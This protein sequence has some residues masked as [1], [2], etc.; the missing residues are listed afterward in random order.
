MLKMLKVLAI[1]LVFSIPLSAQ[2]NFSFHSGLNE[3]SLITRSA[4]QS[5]YMEYLTREGFRPEID[6]DGDIQFRILG[7][8]YFIIIDE[9]D[10]QFF[11]IYTGF[12]LDSMMSIDI[13]EALELVNITN[14]RSK[15][16]K[17]SISNPENSDSLSDRLVVSI[18]AELLLNEPQDFRL[19]F[20]RA[21]SLLTN[22]KNLFQ[23]QLASR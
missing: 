7:N 9:N 1:I 22:A 17:I 21:I 14:R 5:M 2:D 20:P 18:T 4:L 19:I 10:L 6:A 13:E 8:N 11:Q 23:M 3:V 16:A 12:F 15:V